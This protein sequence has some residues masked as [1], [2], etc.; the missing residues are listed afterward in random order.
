MTNDPVARAATGVP[1]NGPPFGFVFSI[2]K[3]GA[4]CIV[5]ANGCAAA[6]VVT[7]APQLHSC[8][9]I[10]PGARI[11]G[12]LSETFG[13]PNSSRDFAVECKA[14]GGANP[15][16]LGNPKCAISPLTEAC[17]PEADLASKKMIQINVLRNGV[18]VPD[19]G[20][21]TCAAVPKTTNCPPVGGSADPVVYEEG[22]KARVAICRVDP[23]KQFGCQKAPLAT[24][25][26][27][28]LNPLGAGAAAM[29]AC[30]FFAFGDVAGKQKV[31]NC[32]TITTQE[33]PRPESLCRA[34][35]S[36]VAVC[37]AADLSELQK[38]GG[39]IA[40]SCSKLVEYVQKSPTEFVLVRGTTEDNGGGLC[41]STVFRGILYNGAH[42]TY[43]SLPAPGLIQ[44]N[45]CS[46]Q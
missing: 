31:T 34:N 27:C 28:K 18:P 41:G 36:T 9:A 30:S 42:G 32:N 16:V 20:T 19:D 14:S 23:A 40:A 45:M 44:K 46:V 12:T 38:A 13:K 25:K 4:Y 7:A 21:A 3:P 29:E 43:F 35:D 8:S 6:P 22:G 11:P 33:N 15:H 37:E 5:N 39:S 26:R 2:N 1:P 17:I 10:I 24:N